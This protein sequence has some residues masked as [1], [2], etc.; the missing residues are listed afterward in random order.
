MSPAGGG[1]G[2]FA[3]EMVKDLKAKVFPGRELK[4]L[5]VEDGRLAVKVV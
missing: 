3:D 4:V 1:Q 5:A 2:S